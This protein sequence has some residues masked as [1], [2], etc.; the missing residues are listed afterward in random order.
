MLI[1]INLEDPKWAIQKIKTKYR[2]GKFRFND[3]RSG[4]FYWKW[5]QMPEVFIKSKRKLDVWNDRESLNY[6]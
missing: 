6:T 2:Y 3:E 1:K 5:A 4:R